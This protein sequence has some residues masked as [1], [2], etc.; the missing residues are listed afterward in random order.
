MAMVSYQDHES[1]RPLDAELLTWPEIVQLFATHEFTPCAPCP[2]GKKCAMKRSQAFSPVTLKVPY[3][4]DENVESVSMLVYDEDHI[5]RAELEAVCDRLEGL[6]ALISSTH[7]HQHNGPDDCCVRL[8]LPL[9]RALNPDEF[10]R[11]YHEV[12]KRYRLDWMRPGAVKSSGADPQTKNLSRLYFLPTAPIGSEV[13]EGHSAGAILDVDDLLRGATPELPR[14]L[15]THSEPA[16]GVPPPSDMDQL[17]K[18]LHAYV[19]RNPEKDDDK[20]ISRKELARRVEAGEPLVRPEEPGLRDDSCHRIGK[21]LANCLPDDATV[22]AVLELVRPSILS[23]PVYDDD[24]EDDTIEA[25]F[26]KV[27]YSFERGL[28][29]RDENR[30]KIAKRREGDARL[31][32]GFQK[33]FAIRKPAA[34]VSDA[35][36]SIEPDFGDDQID[37]EEFKK[38]CDDWESLLKWNP[39]KLDKKGNAIPPTLQNVDAN[40]QAILGFSEPWRQV[41]RYNE[42]T[43]DV[44]VVGGPLADWEN[45]TSQVTTGVKYWLSRESG[46]NIRKNEVMDAIVHVAK[47]NA[48]DPVKNYLNSIEDDGFLPDDFLEIYCGAL[49]VDSDDRD[50]SYMIRRMSRCWLVGAVARGL[51]PGC[52]MDTVLILEGAQGVKKSTMLDVLGGKW[53]TDSPI[54]IGDKDS[55][56]L[57]GRSWIAELAELSAMHASAVEA[58]K[59]FFSS[60]VDKFRPPYGYA[61]EEFPRRCVFAGSTNDERYMNDITGNRRFMPAKCTKFEIKKARRDRDK[62]WAAAVKIYKAGGANCPACVAAKDGEARC[63]EHRWWFTEEENKQLE[64]INNQRLKNEFSEAITDYILKMDPPPPASMPK[65]ERAKLNIR[66]HAFTMYEIATSMLG[67]TPDRVNSQQGPIGRALK[68][69]GFEKSRPR[70]NGILQPWQHVVP[71]DLMHAPRRVRGRHLYAVPKPSAPTAAPRQA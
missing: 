41:L 6:E 66:P 62:I 16:Q 65:E 4:L 36:F 9:S 63:H 64:L 1:P 5:T 53:F 54:V 47:M 48:F 60:R 2:G 28:V 52:K 42:V 13:I 46:L 69:L 11:V 39:E 61:I 40:A 10:R 17:R 59:A 56:M 34:V 25:R 15:R 37:S 20:T 18:A 8:V 51:D 55:K 19:P 45:S 71:Q 57:A 30:E 49:T 58:Q 29:A 38:K 32:E 35:E 24:G 68:S 26:S 3:R 22:E 43:K 27:G 31:R 23:M 67:L 21:I 12:R 33:R 70:I 14:P 50:I 7:S 44:L